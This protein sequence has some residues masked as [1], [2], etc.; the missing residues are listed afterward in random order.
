MPDSPK[1]IE[2]RITDVAGAWKKLRPTKKFSDMTYDEFMAEVKPSLDHRARLK[3]LETEII[4]ETDRRDDADVVSLEAV[5][6][7][8]NSVKG[9]KEEGEDGELYDAMG[10][11]RKSERKSGLTKKKQ[12][13]PEKK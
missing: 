7:V 11:V 3:E 6:R 13:P 1:S 5:N 8:V 4:A 2:T 10:Y 9:D 12:A